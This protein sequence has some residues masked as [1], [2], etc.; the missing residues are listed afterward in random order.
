V[1]ETE[2]GWFGRLWEL[3]FGPAASDPG[4]GL[5]YRKRR[6]G[7][8]PRSQYEARTDRNL[9][10]P[11]PPPAPRVA[12]A[13]TWVYQLQKIDPDKIAASPADVAV[14]D[15]SPDGD[16]KRIFTRDEIARM[17][18]KPD[19]S[20]R[21]LISYM[22]IGEANAAC[23]YWDHRWLTSAGKK[24]R[25]APSWL[26]EPNSSG[27]EGAW[28]VK[29]WDPAWQAIIIDRPDSY[30][31]QIIDQGFDGVYLDIVDG[32]A[33]WMDDD[34]GAD[35]RAS[36][37]DDMIAFIARIGAHARQTRGKPGFLVVPQNGEGLLRDAYFRRVIS[38]I[39][40]EDILFD[41][42]GAANAAPHVTKRQEAGESDKETVESIMADLKLGL[43]ENPPVTVLAVEYLRD[44]PEDIP[45]QPATV[46]RMRELGLVPYL[47][48]RDLAS[49]SPVIAPPADPAG[50]IVA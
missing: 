5:G 36:A 4:S 14:I 21:L 18:T 10:A 47:A 37:G 45:A 43:A 28:K 25:S 11:L 7:S 44:W 29:F 30:L 35:K 17:Q 16:P 23:F 22:S 26:Y 46:A 24:T 2:T 12:P 41:M 20:R 19:G 48:H 9:E 38:G 1:A 32:Y 13:A 40:K 27:W 49:L 6:A 39:G 15:Y 3:L 33:Y 31:N 34:R 50:T 8:R 42:A